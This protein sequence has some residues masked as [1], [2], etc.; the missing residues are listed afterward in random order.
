MV[1]LCPDDHHLGA[2]RLPAA[3]LRTQ[4]AKGRAALKRAVEDDDV[5]GVVQV[6]TNYLVL[7][8]EV[9]YGRDVGG[10]PRAGDMRWVWRVNGGARVDA[11][12]LPFEQIAVAACVMQARLML[13]VD[14][15]GRSA[16]ACYDALA[17][18]WRTRR[19]TVDNPEYW[20]TARGASARLG[21]GAPFVLAAWWQAAEAMARSLGLA[22]LAYETGA[23][24]TAGTADYALDGLARAGALFMASRLVF[25]VEKAQQRYG[26][27]PLVPQAAPGELTQ[28]RLGLVLRAHVHALQGDRPR[29]LAGALAAHAAVVERADV[30][31]HESALAL[32]ANELGA[33]ATRAA[34]DVADAEGWR[35]Q[36]AA[37]AP[38]SEAAFLPDGYVAAAQ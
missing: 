28:H 14:A 22:A 5:R 29:A 35:L 19:A 24:G 9:V 17:Y 2:L 34:S 27:G 36:D 38:P 11:V 4:F 13:A 21:A 18:A 25:R 16:R 12:A 20:W 26:W 8:E 6:G 15:G 37:A 31:R 33:D 10:A 3:D 32:L 23:G 1:S 30:H 7:V